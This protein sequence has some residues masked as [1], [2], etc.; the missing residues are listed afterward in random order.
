MRIIVA[1]R[2]KNENYCKIVA[3]KKTFL[4]G[5]GYC[6]CSRIQNRSWAFEK[7]EV[8]KTLQA[9]QMLSS[10]TL[11]CHKD[12]HEFRF[13]IVRIVVSVSNVTSL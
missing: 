11:K 12:C 2:E 4:S 3:S 7:Q 6:R 5:C 10:V 9:L 8:P 13:S 1:S